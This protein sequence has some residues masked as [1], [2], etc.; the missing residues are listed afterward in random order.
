MTRSERLEAALVALVRDRRSEI[1]ALQSVRVIC[2]TLEIDDT[3]GVTA[4][5]V[6]YDTKRQN[7]YERNRQQQ[8]GAR[9]CVA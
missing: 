4:D 5:Q 8:S 2:I 3:G 9:S 6:R 7:R 1:D